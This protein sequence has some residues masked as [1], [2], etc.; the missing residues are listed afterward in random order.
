M[1]YLI[2]NCMYDGD[3]LS[4][5]GIK[6]M[7]WGIRRYQNEDGSYTEAGK[8]RYGDR[9][10]Y[11]ESHARKLQKRVDK[12]ER[13]KARADEKIIS[14]DEKNRPMTMNRDRY[15]PNAQKRID[16]RINENKQKMA[17]HEKT[18]KA[19][20]KMID[21][22]MKDAKKQ[23]YYTTVDKGVIRSDSAVTA[24]LKASY[25]I[26]INAVYGDVHRISTKDPRRRMGV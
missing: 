5:H 6:G 19:L 18:S 26:P 23:G 24:V 2:G 7:K 9:N 11:S 16:K 4:H 21:Q 22:I 20:G 8:K 14:L 12:L 17:E 13:A 25:G 10:M 1:A 15:S 3:V